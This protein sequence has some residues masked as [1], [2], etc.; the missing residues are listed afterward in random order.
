M[1]RRSI[2]T[3]RD[4]FFLLV[5]VVFLFGCV[6]SSHRSGK[7]LDQGQFS[8]G[9]AYDGLN[10]VSESEADMIHLLAV[11]GRVGVVRGL[12]LGVAHTWDMTGDNDGLF[13]T[14]W[15]DAKVQLNNR[16]NEVGK[17]I[18]SLGVLKGYVYHE[19]ADLHITSFP[20]TVSI[21]INETTT[22]Y[23]IYRF[24]NIHEDFMPSEWDATRHAFIMGSE[25]EIETDG[26]I[27]P[28]FGVDI[29]LL[30]DLYGDDDG[31]MLLI[32]NAGM[33]FNFPSR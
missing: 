1:R 30:S 8:A 26:A 32:I 12:D 14:W 9:I 22:P 24:E 21:P 25:V 5:V 2:L 18:F 31:D 20:V 17:P 7:T 11:D 19:D 6:A 10:N 3:W 23:F 13:S 29:G 15:G 16:E 28:I 33:S 4:Y 27:T